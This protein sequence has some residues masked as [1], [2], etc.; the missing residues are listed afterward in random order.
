MD[1]FGTPLDSQTRAEEENEPQKILTTENFDA[2]MFVRSPKI[3]SSHIILTHLYLIG[4]NPINLKIHKKLV[5]ICIIFFF[6]S[7]Q[8]EMCGTVWWKG[9]QP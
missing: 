8:I 9:Y 6:S 7:F 5:F 1:R 2:K 3:L 4:S